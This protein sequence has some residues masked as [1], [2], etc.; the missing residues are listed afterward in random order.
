M[1][2]ILYIG[3][4]RKHISTLEMAFDNVFQVNNLVELVRYRNV[5]LEVALVVAEKKL[6]GSKIM[7]LKSLL[8]EN[9]VATDK[10][11]MIIGESFSKTERIAFLQDGIA[12]LC[13]ENQNAA[14]VA[15][16]V[17]SRPT[18]IK[19]DE[20]QQMPKTGFAKRAFDIAFAG[21]FLLVASPVLG[22]N[23]F[24]DSLGF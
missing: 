7:D 15:Q 6:P 18:V 1:I 13:D 23:R 4:N 2:N 11:I 24:V 12:E 3:K 17:L 14:K 19:H 5:K 22:D 16:T 20:K 10:P 8:A 9:N 21:T